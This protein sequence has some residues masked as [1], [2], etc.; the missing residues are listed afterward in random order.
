MRSLLGNLGCRFFLFSILSI[1][2]HS[3]LACGI[4][5]ERSSV[6][7]MGF[8]LYATWCFSL[9]TFNILSLCLV[10]VKFISMCPG[11]FLLGFV[12]YG[13]LYIACIDYLF[14]FG[15][16][17]M[18]GKFSTINSSKIF[19]YPFFLLLLGPL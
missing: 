13:T 3:L 11:M 6:N 17:S 4:S 14:P 19:S 15:K 16:I 5:A 18:L 12:L 9:A 2:C 8:P 7:L 10:F 1:F